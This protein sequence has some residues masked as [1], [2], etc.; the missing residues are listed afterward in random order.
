MQKQAIGIIVTLVVAA[1]LAG[2]GA[3]YL[4]QGRLSRLEAKGEDI[5]ED[6]KYMKGILDE[7]RLRVFQGS[8]YSVGGVPAPRATDQVPVGGA[9]APV[10][11]FKTETPEELDPD[12]VSA[13]FERIEDPGAL[14]NMVL[15]GKL[16]ISSI[17]LRSRNSSKQKSVD[18]KYEV[19][20]VVKNL[21]DRDIR[22]RI[23]PGQVFE[24]REFRTGRQNLAAAEPWSQIL[25]ARG[26]ANVRIDSYCLNEGF[27]A[28]NGSPGSIA[29]FKVRDFNA[30]SQA[31]FWNAVKERLEA[32]R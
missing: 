25:P 4:H 14:V 1:I 24:N 3:F 23:D 7:L 29:I 21:T 5:A 18:A 16:E 13:I 27:A 19:A 2:F 12:R 20:M 8:F 31:E 26:S 15:E 28:P 6:V 9:V 10:D 22:I 17:T 32:S 30:R 11:T